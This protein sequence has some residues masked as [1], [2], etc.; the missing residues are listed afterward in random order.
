MS[1]VPL[2]S[3]MATRTPPV[4]EPYARKVPVEFPVGE[5][6]FVCDVNPSSGPVTILVGAAETTGRPIASNA[7]LKSAG[8]LLKRLLVFIWE[9]SPSRHPFRMKAERKRY[10]ARRETGQAAPA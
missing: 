1:L 8:P 4:K 6:V 2:T 7:A 10:S 9:K 3:A 5:Y